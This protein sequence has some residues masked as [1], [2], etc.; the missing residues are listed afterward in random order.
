MLG[1]KV[2]SLV[3]K[4]M[5]AGTHIVTWDGQDNKGNKLASGIYYYRLESGS[6]NKAR[7]MVMLK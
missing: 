6:F 3:D 4:K 5:M 2:K 7:K 1:Q